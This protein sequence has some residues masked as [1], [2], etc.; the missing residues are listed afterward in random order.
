MHRLVDTPQKFRGE[1]LPQG[2]ADLCRP[3][4]RAE[5]QPFAP[6]LTAYVGGHDHDGIAEADPPSGGVREHALLHDLQQNAQHLRV[7]LF[8]LVKQ[9]QT[10][11]PA[12]HRLRQLAAL[13]IAHIAGRRTDQTG[14]ALLFRVLR[15]VKPKHGL[16]GAE[17]LLGQ[18]PAQLCFA[19]AGGAGKQKTGN[20]PARVP[21]TGIAPAHR[22]GNGGHR[23]FLPHNLC[24]QQ[25]LQ[26]QQPLPF[27]GSQ[28]PHRNP[29]SLGHHP[30]DV[31][32]ADAAASYRRLLQVL[33]FVPQLRRPLELP[34]PDGP[35][36][37]FLQF[38]PGR[39]AP[40]RLHFLHPRPGGSLVQ[41]I[42]GLIR[43][44]QIWKVSA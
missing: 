17:D 11:G 16:P 43:Q 25:A 23:L 22:F 29:G 32:P 37:F 24:G 26:F 36:Q 19:H 33:H 9:H 13:L 35:L 10:V 6:N 39:A 42:D 1:G 14:N 38:L 5:A 40:A 31:R 8:Q 15:H 30:G 27:P 3:A 34:L 7:G 2:F 12:A 18:R 21:N 28:P 4:P 20:G 44:V 41:Q